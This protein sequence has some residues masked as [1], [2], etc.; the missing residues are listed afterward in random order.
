[1]K[2]A[3]AD[4]ETYYSETYTLKK[5]TTEAYV[6]DPRF[7]LHCA[8]AKVMDALPA[9][10]QNPIIN[11]TVLNH[12]ALKIAAV[13]VANYG[14]VCHKASFDGLILNH[15]YDARPAFW[16]DTL[17]MARLIFPHEKS[18]SL[19]SLAAK[20]GLPPKIV[21]YNE[22]RNV[23]D[24]SPE[25]YNKLAAG[26]AHDVELTYL[27]FRNL[28][29][30]VPR[31][32]LRVIDMTIRMFTEPTLQLDYQQMQDYYEQVKK[33][34]ENVLAELGVSKSELQSSA[35]FAE[36]LRSLGVEPPTKPSPKNPTKACP[37]CT[38]GVADCPTCKGTGTVTNLVYA[39]AKTDDEMKELCDDEDPRVSALC[40]ARLGQKSTLNETRCSRLLSMSE[41]GAL[42][43]PLRYYGAGATGRF[44]GE[45]LVNFQNF[46]RSGEIRN[47]I[48]APRGYVIL[49]GDLSQI[50]CRMLNWLAGEQWVLDAF[51]DHRD[52]YSEIATDFYGRPI[53]KAE[54]PERGLG[55][56]IV[57]SCGFGSGGPKIVITARRGT[58]GPPVDLSPAQGMAARDLY[59]QKHP[60]VVTLWSTGASIMGNL[61]NGTQTDWNCMKIRD[62]KVYLP[63][64]VWLDYSNLIYKGAGKHGRPDFAVRRR[65]GESRIY[66]SKF[67]Q[68][69]VE[70]LSRLVLTKAM[71]EMQQHYPARLCTHDEGVWLVPEAH[72]VEAAKYLQQL[73]TTPPDWCKDIPLEAEVGYDTRYTK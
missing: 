44:S 6:R 40:T 4:T 27:V 16:F 59:R 17:S 73:L 13:D 25:L 28:L 49:V 22:F 64:G 15:H 65:Q 55:K 31:E 41:R 20:F 60:K 48:I 39:F 36:I 45:D 24:L 12:E 14:M 7:K 10:G 51:R 67:I 9:L 8:A 32:E 72:A 2:F 43:V 50:E 52:L 30:L 56:Q 71:L 62:K 63:N 33:D 38:T 47:C 53:S 21:P 57:L 35:K 19:E 11:T 26:C 1:M 5:M 18:H 69:I 46:P 66:G 68:N 23:R 37:T 54:R 61:F 34:K 3:V 42:T 58:Y 70:A 29:P